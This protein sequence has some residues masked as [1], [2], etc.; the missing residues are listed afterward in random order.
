MFK[1]FEFCLPTSDN[2][3]S[4]G[5]Q[6]LHEIKYDGFRLR[7]EREGDRVSIAARRRLETR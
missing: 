4:A 7:V 3:V 5:P 2:K 6:R 1:A